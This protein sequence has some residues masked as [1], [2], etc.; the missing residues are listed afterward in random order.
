[1][2]KLQCCT[3][4][5]FTNGSEQP[6]Q[7]HVDHVDRRQERAENNW[8]FDRRDGSVLRDNLLQ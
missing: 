3:Y 1:M 8:E 2:T 6:S 4:L 5:D 7:V